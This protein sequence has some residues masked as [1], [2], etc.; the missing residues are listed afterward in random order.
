MF[1]LFPYHTL[2]QVEKPNSP[3]F[4]AAHFGGFQLFLQ[5]LVDKAIPIKMRFICS[6]IVCL[7][8]KAITYIDSFMKQSARWLFN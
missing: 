8:Y 4:L 6:S 7:F 1:L 3:T 2:S 5:H